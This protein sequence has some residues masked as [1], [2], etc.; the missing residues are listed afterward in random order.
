MKIIEI[1]K[2][3]KNFNIYHKFIVWKHKRKL[4]KI[5]NK[6][7]KKAI[8]ENKGYVMVSELEDKY[9]YAEGRKKMAYKK[10]ENEVISLIKNKYGAVYKNSTWCGLIACFDLSMVKDKNS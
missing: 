3:N 4:I 1:K 9:L 8:R 7:A 2:V 5:F 10:A 6:L